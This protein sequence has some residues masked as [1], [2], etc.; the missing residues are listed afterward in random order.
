[1]LNVDSGPLPT[2]LEEVEAVSQ[3]FIVSWSGLDSL[4]SWSDASATVLATSEECLRDSLT[5]PLNHGVIY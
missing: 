3:V 1:M 2:S 4:R 5:S